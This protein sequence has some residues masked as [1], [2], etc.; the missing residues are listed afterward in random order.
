MKKILLALFLLPLSLMAQPR[1]ATSTTATAPAV[2][3]T[4]PAIKQNR[5]IPY[6]VFNTMQ[7]DQALQK[8]TRNP[9]GKPGD[10]YWMQK[11]AYNIDATLDPA[12]K[13]LRGSETITYTNNSPDELRQLVIYLRQNFYKPTAM[14]NRPLRETT[15]GVTLTDV[16]LEIGGASQSVTP[17]INGTQGIIRLANPLKAGQTATLK[18]NFAFTVPAGLYRMGTDGQVHVLAYWY[19]QMAVYDDVKGWDADQ[20]LGNGEFYMDFANYDV[21]ITVPKGFPIVATGTLQNPNDVLSSDVQA[22]LARAMSQDE[23]VNVVTAADRDA[24]KTT[25]TNSDKLTWHFTADNVRDFTFGTSEKWIWDAT[26]A[27]VG[28]RDG[29]GKDDFSLI[30]AFYRPEQKAWVESAKMAKFTIEHLSKRFF[31]YPWAHMSTMEGF[32]GGGME[33]PMVTHI[34]GARN[35][36]SLF[37]VTYHEI[38]HMY[39]PMMIGVD[40]KAYAWMEEGVT[41]FNTADASDDY[42]K[43]ATSWP[44][45]IQ[46]HLRFAGTGQQ[47]E[48]M[49]HTD[50][51][52][53]TSGARSMA[54]YTSPAVMYNT[55]R[56]IVGKDKFMAAFREYANRWKFKHPYPFD[57]FN[58]M[59]DLLKEDL[60]WFWTPAFYTTW[61]LDQSVASVEKKGSNTVITIED[62]GLFPT[63]V[64]VKISY[65]DGTS[66]MKTIPVQTWLS[67]ATTATI[68][69]PR[70]VVTKVE[71]DPDMG[72]P[73][74]DRTNNTWMP[75]N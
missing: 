52:P 41:D 20:Y 34:G 25:L 65:N 27:N 39:F 1:P 6:P 2:R 53:L 14:R 10:K 23:V 38:A 48:I 68:S 7:F 33:F 24:G 4:P 3:F 18:M 70:K 12:G 16:S 71:I 58:T 51:Y 26:R 73:D 61:S 11:V 62:K 75:K 46:Q 59:E 22:K 47:L 30:Q 19:P 67:G 45:E 17:T 15:D 74:K 37:G 64:P 21:K 32:I 56:N 60:D 36:E 13:Q 44:G 9:N 55:L 28:D 29:D 69:I 5:P 43:R 31:P 57:F 8:G 35:A 40:E 72:L 49:R 54:A 42:W 66:E 50:Q 63:P